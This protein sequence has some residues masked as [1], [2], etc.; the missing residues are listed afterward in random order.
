MGFYSKAHY[1]RVS[2]PSD[3]AADIAARKRHYRALELARADVAARF[4]GGITPENAC[5]VLDYQ[6]AR[7]KVRVEE[8]K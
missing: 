8:A 2:P 6:E 7:I 1:R 3:T 4:P 5:E